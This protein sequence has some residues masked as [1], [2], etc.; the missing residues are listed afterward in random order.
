MTRRVQQEGLRAILIA[1]GVRR[2]KYIPCGVRGVPL[3]ARNW[4]HS[5]APLCR[6]WD[7]QPARTVWAVPS[8]CCAAVALGLGQR[9]GQLSRCGARWAVRGRLRVREGEG[10]SPPYCWLQ[11]RRASEPQHRRR[12]APGNPTDSLDGSGA[13]RSACSPLRS[14]HPPV[15]WGS[16]PAAVRSA[17]VDDP[18]KQREVGR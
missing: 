7:Q 16:D 3:T 18:A 10:G 1:A 6:V 11:P 12:R 17:G 15:A 9:C 4:P 2:N 13:A 8:C 14:A 5:V